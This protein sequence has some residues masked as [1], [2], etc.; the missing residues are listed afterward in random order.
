MLIVRITAHKVQ[1]FRGGILVERIAVF[2]AGYH[3]KRLH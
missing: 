2:K 1:R 3:K